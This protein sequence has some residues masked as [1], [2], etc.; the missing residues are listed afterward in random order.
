MLKVSLIMLFLQIFTGGNTTISENRFK[1]QMHYK[2]CQ[3]I[4]GLVKRQLVNH[5]LLHILRGKKTHQ[6]L[7]EHR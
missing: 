3:T 2:Q 7:T 4:S 6:L 5:R 1:K